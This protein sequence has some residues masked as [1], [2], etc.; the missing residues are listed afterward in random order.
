MYFWP[1]TSHCCFSSLPVVSFKA[2]S[3]Y[4]FQSKWQVWRLHGF[5]LFTP[6]FFMTTRSTVYF[7]R[8][9]VIL[10]LVSDLLCEHRIRIRDRAEAAI[11]IGLP[12][13]VEHGIDQ[14]IPPVLLS[15]LSHSALFFLTFGISGH[16]YYWQIFQEGS[17]SASTCCWM[18]EVNYK[19]RI[20]QRKLCVYGVCIVLFFSFF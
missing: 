20:S 12:L 2:S 7:H 13:L 11:R 5:P 19:E 3:L 9:L 6:A 4:K 10:H 8:I 16:R 18:K 14:T 1:A 17:C 15:F